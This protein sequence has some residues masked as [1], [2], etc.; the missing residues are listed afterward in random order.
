M[1]Y[2]RC[3][4]WL[5]NDSLSTFFE[6]GDYDPKSMTVGFC[7]S[8]CFFK[9]YVYIGLAEETVNVTHCEKLKPPFHGTVNQ[10]NSTAI[11]SCFQGYH[12]QGVNIIQCN[13]STSTWNGPT[14]PLCNE[15]IE[16]ENKEPIKNGNF[17][18]FFKEY[19][20]DLFLAVVVIITG[21]LIIV[22]IICR[23]KHRQNP[24]ELVADASSVVSVP[25]MK[26]STLLH[27]GSI[28][29]FEVTDGNELTERESTF[30]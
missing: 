10:T 16:F 14:D 3:S 2:L 24:E 4:R 11:F 15:N 26:S 5:Q 30:L 20:G 17:F 6:Y 19:A 29:F 12:L 21:I 22:T 7:S 23:T 1:Q 18:D 28:R 8:I 13:K 25:A 9:Q 27:D